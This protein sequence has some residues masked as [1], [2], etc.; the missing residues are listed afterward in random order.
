MNFEDMLHQ[1][2]VDV[3]NI[4]ANASAAAT[5]NVKDSDYEQLKEAKGFSETFEEKYFQGLD[6]IETTNGKPNSSKKPRVL[7]VKRK[8][9]K[10]KVDD[11]LFSNHYKSLKACVLENRIQKM[12]DIEKMLKGEQVREETCEKDS[13]NFLKRRKDDR[14]VL[15]ILK[16]NEK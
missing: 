8:L 4:K 1:M 16:E 2:E 11:L 15:K 14:L 9:Y 12:T 6:E 10:I 7:P 3:L 13:K 5:V